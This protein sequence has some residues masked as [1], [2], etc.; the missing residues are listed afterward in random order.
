MKL[1]LPQSGNQID[2]GTRATI[3]PI[4]TTRF[5]NQQGQ[6]HDISMVLSL[7]STANGGNEH[8]GNATV[9]TGDKHGI[10]RH[11]TPR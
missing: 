7:F 6:V 3:M 10:G 1:P 5:T 11:F 4:R 8:I 9:S 2:P